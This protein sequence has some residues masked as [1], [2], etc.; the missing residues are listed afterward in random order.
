M[1]V[2]EAQGLVRDFAGVARGPRVT[3][4]AGLDLDIARGRIFGLLGPNGSGKTTTILMLLG[5][6]KPT[7]GTVRILGH[8]AGHRHARAK[9]GF[10][11]EETR[12]YEFLTGAETLDF[13]GRLFSIPRAERR[14]RTD[15]LLKRTGM[16][17]AKDR[18]LHTYSKGMARRIG[19]AQALIAQPE[20]LILD[21]PTSGLDPVGNRAVRDMLREIAAD[22]TTILLTSHILSDVAEVCDEI[23]I[24]HRGRRI[25]AGEVK[26]LLKDAKRCVWETDVPSAGARERI[27]EV[28]AE[29]GLELHGAHPPATTLEA[30]FLEAL[31][32]DLA[33]GTGP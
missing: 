26:D 14:K 24:L 6:L 29:A 18:R 13:I 2:I 17:E 33:S 5:L 21:E 3:A 9:T 23:A 1:S 27:E 4:V 8:P 7:S 25:L 31:E 19:L 20:L 12:L 10:L 15:V 22:G 28:F 32:Q 11:P 16:W 30:L